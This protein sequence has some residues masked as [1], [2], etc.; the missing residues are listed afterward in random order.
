MSDVQSKPKNGGES[1]SSAFTEQ[2]ADKDEVLKMWRHD[3]ENQP[4]RKLN[5]TEKEIY[6][7]AIR[8]AVT[9]FSSMSPALALLSPMVDATAETAYTDQ[10]SR[11]GLSYWFFYV[12][13]SRQ[14]ATWI[15][16]EAMHITNNHFARGHALGL[17]PQR[18]NIMGDLEI[19]TTL[20]LLSD[21]N[22]INLL[23]PE[24]YSLPV[25]K[26]MEI[27]T[28]LTD[29]ETEEKIKQDSPDANSSD[30][31]GSSDDTDSS[32]SQP[33][34][35]DS[36]EESDPGEGSEDDSSGGQGSG[37]GNGNGQGSG[38]SSSGNS[39]EN[40]SSSSTDG[41]RSDSG[42]SQPMS[43]EDRLAQDLDN[44]TKSPAPQGTRHCDE[45]TEKRGNAADLA[46]I[47]KKSA[48]DQN[49]ARSNVR[50]KM[51]D[52]MNST[53]NRGYGE[54]NEFLN[55]V[56]QLMSPPKV[57]WRDILR[58]AVGKVYANVVMGKSQMSYR[59]VNKR[60]SQG[61]I[62]FPGTVDIAPNT[63]FGIDTSGSMGQ[64]DY[65]VTMN[66][67]EG[68]L[69]EVSRA[70]GAIKVFPVDTTV[71]NIKPV[72]N[73]RDIDF[74]GGGGTDMSVAFAYVNNL[75]KKEKPDIF[76]L[77]TDGYTDWNSVERELRKVEA[78]YYRSIILI[79]SK[80]SIDGVSD[81]VK[82]LALVVDI[83]DANAKNDWEY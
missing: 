65:A 70:K 9:M 36:D 10:H 73:V 33:G 71:K 20:Q 57:S 63:M 68:I 83:S 45:P 48:T 43:M 26:T 21:S 74:V 8:R 11:V 16:H 64:N 62:I 3:M 53:K 17:T 23:L 34:E 61:R 81:S 66:E 32:D 5:K 29:E 60:Y 24:N 7:G 49:I 18:G 38:N 69:Q 51:V 15:L 76:V 58:S 75:P 14:R 72:K 22:L 2:L 6:A 55:I 46:E 13:D 35:G 12:C 42:S 25:R 39:G 59:K 40:S 31:D 56:M 79:T 80:G 82:Q 30:G 78:T 52:H 47:E 28:A 77:S 1:L 54:A 19:N 67:V 44:R 41:N 27:Y 4:I 50:A 37:D